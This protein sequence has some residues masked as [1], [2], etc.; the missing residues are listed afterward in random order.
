MFDPFE[1]LPASQ[2]ACYLRQALQNN[3]VTHAYLITGPRT[4]GHDELALRFAAALVAADSAEE[5]KLACQG[6]HPD[7]HVLHPGSQVG[8][9]VGQAR[10]AVHDAT[11]APVRAQCKVYILHDADKMNGASANAF[12]KTLEE[13]PASVHIILLAATEG[14]VLQT[15]R[16]RCQVLAVPPQMQGSAQEDAQ[17]VEIAS[18]MERMPR[19][20]NAELLQAAKRLADAAVED[21]AEAKEEHAQKQA[22]VADYLTTGARKDLEQAH[23]REEN[24]QQRAVLNAQMDAA[25]SWLRDCL[26]IK[27]GAPGL[28]ED[29]GKAASQVS[30]GFGGGALFASPAKNALAQQASMAGILAA[31]QA[32]DNTRV[33]VSCNVTP[34]LAMEAMLLEIR[35][36]LCLK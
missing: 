4:S 24:M 7:I 17:R 1:G 36:A 29:S 32:V 8:Y 15:L 33:R 20:G 35:E 31:I 12:L 18:V 26:M 34:Q 14:G 28:V 22:E 27:S 5:F 30:L 3:A 6:A 25:Q 16:S 19:L 13:P 10:E 9:V 23:K 11:L 21:V 2:A